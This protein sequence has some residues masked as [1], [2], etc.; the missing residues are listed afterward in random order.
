MT[1]LIRRHFY[2]PDLMSDVR[3]YCRSCTI[4]QKRRAPPKRPHHP[5]QQDRVG[6]P[7]QRLTVDILSFDRPTARGNRYILVAVDTLTKWAEAM[8]LADERAETVAAA[9]VEQVV[10]RLGIPAQLHSDQGRQFE[11]AVFQQM[12]QLLG[13]RKT[14][15]T[16]YHPQGDGQT[17]RV[18]RTL[19]NVLA[20]MAADCPNDWDLKLSYAMAAY[21][22]TPHTTTG[23][24]PNRLM[25]GRESTTPLTLLAPVVPDG[26]P[27]Q[28]WVENLHENFAEAHAR[29]QEHI[30]K[31]Q[32]SQ[33]RS[34]D[35][36][37]RGYAFNVGDRVWLLHNQGRKGI[38]YKLN[39]YRWRGP[40]EIR[41]RLSAAV[42]VIALVGGRNE[43]VVNADRLTPCIDR[44]PEF[45]QTPSGAETPAGEV[46]EVL[47]ERT[48]YVANEL[49]NGVAEDA[50]L[51]PRKRPQR[52]RRA[53][54]WSNEYD[55]L[56]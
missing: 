52:T 15:T 20:K 38:P 31:A 41:K 10:C 19:L 54:A 24:S 55:L 17:E 13:I 21:R 33:K 53:P 7:M 36:R 37:Q 3:H 48:D 18:N 56:D 4:C 32:R 35:A 34:H 11:A 49:V 47:P 23:E 16:P 39:A 26:E 40:Y 2:W 30:C 42:F 50:P 46:N 9:L 43:T 8:P 6:E 44:R 5:L 12:C 25:L 28:P 27:K 29:V 45:Q 1:K 51:M 14:R 22:S